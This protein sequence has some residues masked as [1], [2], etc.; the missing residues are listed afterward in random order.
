MAPDTATLSLT[1]AA[2]PEMLLKGVYSMKFSK[3]S[4]IQSVALPLILAEY[5]S[6]TVLLT[7]PIVSTTGD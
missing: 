7:Q 1:A 3:P 2:S 4:K 6:L 5:V